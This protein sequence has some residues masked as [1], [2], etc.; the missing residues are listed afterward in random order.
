MYNVHCTMYNVQWAMYNDIT[1]NVQCTLYTG[2]LQ[3]ILCTVQ[4]T[5][6][7]RGCS[8]FYIILRTELQVPNRSGNNAAKFQQKIM[9]ATPRKMPFYVCA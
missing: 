4:C 1:Y 8:N 9:T 3:C 7:S 2:T 6:Y 5:L